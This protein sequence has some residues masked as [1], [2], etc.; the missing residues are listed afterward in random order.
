[1]KK[2]ILV[3]D[4]EY[5]IRELVELSLDEDYEIYKAQD[6]QEAL[7]KAELI[8]DLI[9]LDV[10]MPNI[11]GYE[12]CEKIKTSEKTKHIPVIMLTVKHTPEDL[13]KAIACNVDEFITKPFEPGLLKKRVDSYFTGEKQKSKLMQ[14][15]RSIHYVKGQDS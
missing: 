14:V 5:T 11:D 1:M 4:D 8:P 6:G 9:I 7:E 10:M 15:D 12:V 2:K 13:E 3:V